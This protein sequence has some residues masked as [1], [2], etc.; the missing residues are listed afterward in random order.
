MP[1]AAE[2]RL[3]LARS[4]SASSRQTLS[5]FVYM[6]LLSMMI[7]LVLQVGPLRLSVYRICLILAL[8]PALSVLLS[9]RAGRITITD[10]CVFLIC[11]W[12][13]LS[14][15]VHHGLAQTFEAVGIFNIETLGAYLLGRCFVRTPEAFK[16]VTKAIFT[17]ALIMI[18]FAL[19]ETL[20]GRNLFLQMFDAIGQVFPDVYKPRRWGLDRVQG[21]FEHPILIGVFFGSFA[22][23]AFFV[24][25]HGRSLW[26]RSLMASPVAAVG[27]SAFSSGP[28]AG[29]AAQ[30]MFIVWAKVFARVKLRWYLFSGLAILAYV[31]VDLISTRSPFA[32]FISYLAF[33]AH[34]AYN[35]LLIYEWGMINILENP[36][37]GLGQNEWRRPWYMS[38]SFDMY[39]LIP[40]L[41]YGIP[42][43]ALNMFLFLWL[44]FAAA[45]TRLKSDRLLDYRLGYTCSMFGFFLSGWTVH[46]WNAT[47]VVFIFFLASG[48]WLINYDEPQGALVSTDPVPDMPRGPVYT[49]F[50]NSQAHRPSP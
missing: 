39:W 44:F 23:T 31:V 25:G 11:F 41:R 42:A 1:P 2:L 36:L 34:T 16:A 9:G 47:Y 21:P 20:T 46:F 30:I 49:R 15:T 12:S 3:P 10:I 26:R 40:G 35:R 5:V 38:T 29:L 4:D 32:V 13:S 6:F 19:F 50:P 37:F 17:M 24:L 18:P 8:L 45:F 43:L 28:L 22:G 48:L 14:L 27:I 7:P 33:N